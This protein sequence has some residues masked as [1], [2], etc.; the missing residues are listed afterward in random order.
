MYSHVF[1]RSPLTRS[2]SLCREVPLLVDTSLKDPPS[3]EVIK[4]CKRSSLGVIRPLSEDLVLPITIPYDPLV[5]SVLR[6]E[7]RDIVMSE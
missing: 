3:Y 7:A 1:L 5:W 2:H 6:C 4:S